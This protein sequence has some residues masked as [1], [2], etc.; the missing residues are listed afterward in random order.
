MSFLGKKSKDKKRERELKQKLGIDQKVLEGKF[1]ILT[2]YSYT[3]LLPY[4]NL[5]TLL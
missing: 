2:N 3:C 1:S 5:L 4:I